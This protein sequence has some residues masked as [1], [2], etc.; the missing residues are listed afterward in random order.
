MSLPRHLAPLL[1]LATACTG[2]IDDPSGIA[3]EG[4]SRSPG[5][6]PTVEREYGPFSPAGAPMRRLTQAQYRNVIADLFG[7][8]TITSDL[9]ADETTA[10]FS[11]IGASTV[12]TSNRG[13]EQYQVAALEIAEQVLATSE[14][15]PIL[16]GCAPS[17][18]TDPCIAGV[19]EHFGE[20]LFRRPLAADEVDRYAAIAGAAGEEPTLLALGMRYVLAALLASPSFLYVPQVG[21]LDPDLGLQRFTSYEMAARLA[22]FL[23]DSGPDRELLD[24][25]RAGDLDT[26]EGIAEQ[27]RRMLAAPRARTL[28]SRFFGEAWGVGALAWEDKNTD[29]FPAWTPEL[30]TSMRGEV[31][32]FLE[33]LVFARDADIREVLVARETFVDAELAAFYGL[34]SPAGGGFE[35]VS[36]DGTR[37]GLLTAGAVVAANSPSDR[38]SPTHRGLFV[39]ERILCEEIP[40]PPANVDDTLVRDGDPD[41]PTTLRERLERHRTDPTCAGCHQLF[42]PLGMTFESFDAVGTFRTHDGDLP[43][44]TRGELDDATFEDVG[45]LAQYLYEDPRTPRCMAEQVYE[46]AVGHELTTGEEAVLESVAEGLIED[47]HRF[48]ELVV[49]VVTSDGFRYLATE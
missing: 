34:D 46:L 38:S 19:V 47:G 6:T 45:D 18:S 4:A 24:A 30:L 39:I 11:S 42:D 31:D 2:V 13:V 35:R 40:P 5:E 25:A 44:D 15:H 16:A 43:V 8:L 9:E 28:P 12:A 23:W 49:H 41:A 20:L 22:L 3:G 27:A 26:P 17:S 37:H 29:V 32:R 33:D 10:A 1:A 36:L 7:D 48:N 14:R 21:E